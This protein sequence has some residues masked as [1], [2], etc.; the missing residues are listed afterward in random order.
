[1][2]G[3]VSRASPPLL[4][5]MLYACKVHKASRSS[6]SIEDDEPT[7]TNP[8][9]IPKTPERGRGWVRTRD[10]NNPRIHT[11]QFLKKTLRECPRQRNR[12]NGPNTV[13]G[14]TVSNTELS[15]FFGAHRVLGSELSE[16]LSAYYLCQ[17]ELTEFFA[18]L[19]EFAA[20]LSEFSLPKQYSQNS[21]PPVAS[22][23]SCGFPSIPGIGPGV[24]PRIVVF[25][26]LKSW[27][28]IPRME[29]RIPR[30]AFRIPKAAP[31]IPRNS[32]RAP[33]NGLF[34]PRAFFPE[35]EVVPRLLINAGGLPRLKKGQRFLHVTFRTGGSLRIFSGYF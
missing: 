8:E 28:A 10:V 7:N 21:I 6:A 11:P 33:R 2:G 35:I 31:R 12:R 1:M 17:S 22:N 20:E 4:L 27:D 18:E 5:C 19:T 34:T 9:E 30:T 26:L 15:E 29:F 23:L 14:S 13:S 16:F 3:G 25:V 32:P 24:A